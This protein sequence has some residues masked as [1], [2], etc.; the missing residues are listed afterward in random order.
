MLE[1]NGDLWGFAGIQVITT[2]GITRKDG[3]AV[4]GRGCARQA[5]VRYPQLP[6][7]LGEALKDMGNHCY[8]FYEYNLITFPVKLAWY[9]MASP[10]LI[11]QSAKELME[12]ITKHTISD[13]LYL[14]RP[15]CGN[16]QLL[17]IDVKP[18]IKDILSDQVT[19]VDF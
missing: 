12:L 6:L 2:N 5:A 19:V 1:V 9:A 15:G 4:M 17:W 10:G 14:A 3:A 18:L 16:G 13:Q 11:I 7:T 8:Y